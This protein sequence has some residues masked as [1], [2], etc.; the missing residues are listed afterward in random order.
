MAKRYALANMRVQP[1]GPGHFRL[2]DRMLE[3]HDTVIIGIG[4]T[5]VSRELANPFTFE[6]RKQMLINVYGDKIKIVPLRDLGTSAST[7]EWCDYVL[8]KIKSIG[9]PDPTDYYAGSKADAIWYRNRFLNAD[10]G[11]ELDLSEDEFKS[12]Y[13]PNGEIRLLHVINRESSGLPSGTEIRTFIQTRTDEWK[14]Y[15]PAVN[16]E[17]IEKC[18]PEELKIKLDD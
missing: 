13:M 15:I 1:P 4:S 14:K 12:R 8:R 7:N 5:Q 11:S 17:I 18:Y 6:E 10:V 3:N 2:I 16:H 9:L